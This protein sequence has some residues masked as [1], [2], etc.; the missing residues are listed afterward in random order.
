M[1][2]PVK[3]LNPSLIPVRDAFVSAYAASRL[4]SDIVSR[5]IAKYGDRPQGGFVS[6]I[7]SEHF[8]KALRTRLRDLAHKVTTEGERAE[9]LRPKRVRWDTIRAI[10]QQV[11]ATQGKGYY[12]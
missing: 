6:G 4:W 2:N 12:G 10:R 8:P 3:T 9:N 7:Y 5:A 1:T 11:I